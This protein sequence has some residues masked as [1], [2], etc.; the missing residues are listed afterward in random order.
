MLF[1]IYWMIISSFKTSTELLS[2][3]PTLWPQQFIWQ[4]YPNRAPFLRYL[5]NT[6]VTTLCIMAG[7][8]TIAMAAYGTSPRAN[9]RARTCCSCWCWAR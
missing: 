9:S 4:N 5:V 8:L 6:L 7:E 2:P 3:V 1:P